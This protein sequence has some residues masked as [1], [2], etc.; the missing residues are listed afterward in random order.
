MNDLAG[1][2]SQP[3]R[4][5]S[6]PGWVAWSALG[7]MIATS[8]ALAVL[9]VAGITFRGAVIGPQGVGI[10]GVL[11]AVVGAVLRRP[12]S[13][14]ARVLGGGMGGVVAGWFAV[15]AVELLP[16]AT[17][18]WAYSGGA[19]AALCALPVA[20]VVGGLIGLLSAVSRSSGIGN[21]TTTHKGRRADEGGTAQL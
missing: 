8:V 3:A 7:A 18:Q 9:L 4:T 2:T 17:M 11:G 20:A 12:G 21:A 6:A 1:Q 19:F 14:L 16:P 5:S 10:C 15:S 13:K